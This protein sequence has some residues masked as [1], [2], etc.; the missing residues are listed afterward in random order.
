MTAKQYLSRL[1]QIETRIEHKQ[2]ELAMLDTAAQRITPSAGGAGGG[3]SSD[4][5]GNTIAR[6]VDL[7][8]EIDADIDELVDKRDKII[9]Q[10][11]EMDNPEYMRILFARYVKHMPLKRIAEDMH[12]AYPSIRRMHGWALQAFAAKHLTQADTQ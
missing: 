6:K 4:K 12:Y 8:R 10:I 2:Q 9:N 11:H 5:V 3:G 1:R 7:E